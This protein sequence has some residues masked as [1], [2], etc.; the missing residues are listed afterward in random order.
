M[1]GRLVYGLCQERTF[2]GSLTAP[3]TKGPLHELADRSHPPE[4]L[5][6]QCAGCQRMIFSKDFAA[7]M[8]VCADCGHHTRGS[9]IERLEWT[10]DKDGYTRIELP[11]AVSD[12]L[13]F[14]DTKR[15]ADRLKEARE[16]TH[17]D[18]AVVVG[19]GAI[20]G[21]RAVVA[22]MEFAFI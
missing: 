6:S 16:A 18:D 21:Q 20:D 10:F 1:R 9:A 11:K 12:P 13:K 2:S 7:N 14:R 22:A 19:H 5:W 17:L 15:Y 4:N 3:L 8:R